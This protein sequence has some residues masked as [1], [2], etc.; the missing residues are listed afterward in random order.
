MKQSS[1]HE[2]NHAH[3]GH[4]QT[5]A[6]AIP[7]H[8]DHMAQPDHESMD[9][10]EHDHAMHDLNYRGSELL[11][12]ASEPMNH[13]EHSAMAHAH[14]T[15]HDA[16]AGH[17]VMHEGHATMMR[18]RFFVVLPLTI[19][20]VLY[21]PM[22][23]A[24]LGFTMPQFP[25]SNLIAPVLGT[26]I[27]FYGG[28]PFLSMARQEL[29]LRQPGMMTLI[30]LAITAAYLYSL[31]IFFFPPQP[32]MDMGGMP[33]LPTMDFFWELAT[34][35]AVMLLGHWIELR[36]VGQA[37]GALR[38][39]AKLLPDTAE[40][41]LPSGETETVE[42]GQLRV[43][44]RVLIRP[45]GSIPAD[46]V[47]VDGESSVNESMITGESRPVDKA[48]G[49]TVIGGTVNGSG[50]LRV[51]VTQVGEG[52]ALAGIMRLVEDA[53]KSQSR[54][55]TLAQRAAFYLTIIA[56][57]AGVLTLIGWLVFTGSVSEAV[58]NMVTVLVIACP[59][60]L[61]LAVPL[62]V[63]ISTTLSARSG[64]LVRQRLA[65]ESAKDLNTIIFDKTG[66]LTKGEQGV[67]Q[68][69][70]DGITETDALRIAAG[71]E[72][73]SE[74]MIA[75]AI[76]HYV[77]ERGVPPA[78]VSRFESLAGRGVRAVVDGTAYYIGGP[79]LLEQVQLSVP[80]AL[81]QV[82][83][84]AESAGQSVIYLTTETKVLALFA[85]ADVI[86]EESREAVRKLH[87]LGLKVAML[88]GDSEPVARA[89]AKELNI[90]TY[91][92]Q[93][94]P[95]HKADKVRELQRGGNKVAMVG[96][97]VN[98]A[99]ALVT[100]DVGI[101]IGAGTDVAIESA[102]IILVRSNPL[103][104]V[105][106]VRLS[107]ATYGKMIQ[108]L[109]WATGY[110]VVAIP[111]AMGILAPFGITLDPAIGAVF[112]SVSTVV[113]AFNA[114]LLRRLDLSAA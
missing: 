83:Q 71:L 41:L 113:V 18:N 63:A 29:A 106:I 51:E 31:A 98:D 69:A 54:A 34:L 16:H 47:V 28:L 44:D 82:K 7:D 57:A 58:K 84:G 45:G 36:S 76:R 22:V 50:S 49:T 95:E 42:V 40:R 79:R 102:G 25:G 56:I 81:A 96:D 32:Q 75:Q 61:G 39:L 109:I 112:M 73:D 80:T 101:A 27:F 23:Q 12:P 4:H 10:V 108:N 24:W 104:I 111:L 55:Q 105:K 38:E 8:S 20:V 13:A 89:V 92:A 110:N 11:K 33:T 72:G 86:R 48:A 43:G 65:L 68:V 5:S 87:D 78:A 93:V 3:H 59:H 90:D 30:S 6:P 1:E 70:V 9:H 21:S 66:T 46:G 35:I 14:G 2:H 53:Q 19:I 77:Q 114:Q 91:F 17:G 60:A 62:V 99:P 37:Q 97:G 85:I 94:L 107:R 26:F 15:A 64:L 100:A 103:D 52:T 88:T 74:H 67:V